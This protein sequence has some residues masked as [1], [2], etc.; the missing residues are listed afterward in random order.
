MKLRL[1]IS[2]QIASRIVPGIDPRDLLELVAANAASEDTRR[3]IERAESR[4]Q[5]LALLLMSPEFQRR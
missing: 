2:A 5:A 4:Q 3:T 1:D